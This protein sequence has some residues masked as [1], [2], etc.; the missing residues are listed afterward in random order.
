MLQ[1][2]FII[3]LL[4][5]M[6]ISLSFDNA[7]VNAKVLN[8]MKP[9]WRWRFL[10]W[11]IVV[12]VLG[13]RLLFPILIVSTTAS[14]SLQD[15]VKL[16]LHDPVS[17]S[18]HVAASHIQIAAFG[19][20]FLMLV[21]LN[22][23]FDEEKDVHWLWI[24][25]H[26]VKVGMVAGVPIMIALMAL[27]LAAPEGQEMK[28]V[29]SGIIGIITYI[30]IKGF[31]GFMASG[32]DDPKFSGIAMFIYLEI[33]DMSFSL[34]GVIGAF[35]LSNNIFIIMIGLG[36]GAFFVRYL[37]VRLVNN[38][39]LREYLYLEHGAHYGIA[40][41]SIIMLVS[42]TYQ[43]PQLVTGLIGVGFIGLAMMSSIRHRKTEKHRVRV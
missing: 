5:V 16:A 27:I 26:L 34:D 3:A 25:R 30:A 2:I 13:M 21:F 40:A 15:V 36:I 20:M 29:I 17:Y 41:L 28:A 22:F 32:A 39:S 7:V 37:T 19:S 43:V 12:A 38:G 33:L 42:M 9:V 24:E 1:T 35:A 6:E 31:A 14:M 4:A 18:V 10:T 8:G 11:G 23:I